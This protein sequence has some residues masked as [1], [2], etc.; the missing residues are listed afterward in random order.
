MDLRDF[1]N[2]AN[3]TKVGAAEFAPTV[4]NSKYYKDKMKTVLASKYQLDAIVKDFPGLDEDT[5][6]SIAVPF[7][8]IMALECGLY[9]LSFIGN[10]L[11]A[12]KSVCGMTFLSSKEEMRDNDLGELITGLSTVKKLCE[13]VQAVVTKKAQLKDNNSKNKMRALRGDQ[14]DETHT[15]L[16]WWREI[17]C[18]PPLTMI[19]ELCD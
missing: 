6:P 17:W 11:Y 12:V 1:S 4:F 7:L 8:L 10:G 9:T 19:T 16:T 13:E 14:G 5:I 2:A 18:P 3:T 15:Q